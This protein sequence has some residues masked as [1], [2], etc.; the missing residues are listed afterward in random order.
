[1]SNPHDY[2]V[3]WI[4]AVSTERVAAEAFLDESNHE[5][6]AF[7]SPHD[8]NSYKLGKIGGHMVVIAVLPDGEYGT[9]SAACVARDLLHT[10]PN[11]RIGLMVGIG[12][13]APS[14]KHDIRLGDIVVGATCGGKSG[15]LQYDFGKAIQNQPLEMTRF[16]NQAPSILRTAIAG[17]RA[18]HEIDG[19]DIQDAIE[20]ALAKKPRLRKKYKLPGHENDR[21]YQSHIIHQNGSCPENCGD[22]ESVLVARPERTDED[23]D[24]TI[25]YGAIA[26]ADKLMKDANIRDRLAREHGVLCFEMEAAG[27]MNHF[28]CLIIRGIC[29]YSDTHKNDQW[30]GYAAMVAA[31]YAKDLLLRIVPSSIENERKIADILSNLEGSV[32]NVNEELKPISR[33][34]H[35]RHDRVI[36]EWLTSHDYAISHKD[37]FTKAEPGTGQWFLESQAFQTWLNNDAQ[38]N[39]LLTE[40]RQMPDVGIAYI[41]CNYQRHTQQRATDIL[42]SLL[43]QLAQT[44]SPL[45]TSV[46]DLYKGH[47]RF[48]TQ[49]TLKQISEALSLVAGEFSKVYIVIDALDECNATDNTRVTVLREIYRLQKHMT[50][51]IFATSRP[52]KEVSNVF[53]G[54]LTLDITATDDDVRMYLDTQISLQESLIIDNP[55]KAEIKDKIVAIADG[56]FLLASLQAGTVLSQPTKGDLLETLETLTRGEQGLD[57]HYYQA[58]NR[59]QDQEPNRKALALKILTWIVHSKRPL[60]LRELQH[61]L[62]VRKNTKE[63]DP[64]FIPHPEIILSLCAGLVVLDKESTV[65]RLVHYTTQEYFE[66]ERERWFKDPETELTMT[67][68]TYLSFD[69]F[70]K[71]DRKVYA[72]EYSDGYSYC[73]TDLE[74]NLE[75]HPFY[76]YSA[77]HWGNHAQSATAQVNELLLYFLMSDSHVNASGYA[78]MPRLDGDSLRLAVTTSGMHLAAYFGLSSLARCLL[79][80]GFAPDQMDSGHRTPLSYAAEYKQE[81]IV[82]LLLARDDVDPDSPSADGETPLMLAVMNGHKAIFELISERSDIRINKWDTYGKTALHWAV[83]ARDKSIVARLLERGADLEMEDSQGQTVLSVAAGNG[84]TSMVSFLLHNGAN[85]NPKQKEGNRKTALA[86]AAQ[87]GHEEVVRLLVSTE[88]VVIDTKDN[89]GRSPLIHAASLGHEGIARL[90]L[91]RGANPE[92]RDTYRYGGYPLHHATIGGHMGVVMLL[93]QRD[94]DP[95]QVDRDGRTPFSYAAQL[96]HIEI[97]KLLLASAKVDP[98][99]KC[100]NEY[101]EGRTPLSYAAEGG[102]ESIVEFLLD[103]CGVDPDSKAT[104]RAAAGWTPLMYAASTQRVAIVNILLR[105]DRVDPDARASDAL[106][107]GRTPLSFAAQ[108]CAEAVG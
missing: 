76:F 52:N 18:R 99:S 12:G 45:P 2:T 44:Q 23:D 39:H 77:H 14:N 100:S 3:A 28:P 92:L 35:T 51:N 60:F 30:Q 27:L 49:P 65:V 21:L 79:D 75:E 17:L 88:G 67:C 46:Q 10:F 58:M 93:L 47:E 37:I 16:M 61:A 54:S 71:A 96:G 31:A 81:T 108:G 62:A 73:P 102:D 74:V 42:S 11:V 22:G 53:G 97:A 98:D 70:G 104:G 1:M 91:D 89:M 95:D 43:R 64:N 86:F 63:L 50:V 36:L 66:R 105:T 56:M 6:P 94:V 26:S 38:M 7:R 24:P 68:V 87:N 20:Q 107:I 82:R 40:F 34:I 13:G 80:R 83:T 101:D 106:Y 69:I 8:N 103:T 5:L 57:D 55:L 85:S 48:R 78:I 72:K 32:N 9:S 90:L 59:I 25:H 33:I 41:Y 84:D 29:D 15:V 19:H 4:C